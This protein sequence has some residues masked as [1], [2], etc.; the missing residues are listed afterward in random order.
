[1]AKFKIISTTTGHT[2]FESVTLYE[3]LKFV[4]IPES[5]HMAIYMSEPGEEFHFDVTK[6]LSVKLI[7]ID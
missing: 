6:E 4:D 2:F 1:M 7:K 3:V 5:Q